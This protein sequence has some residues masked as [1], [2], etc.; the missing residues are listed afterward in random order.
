MARNLEVPWALA[1]LTDG[2]MLIAERPGRLRLISADQ[3]RQGNLDD[4]GRLVA[5][6]QPVEHRGEGGLL[7]MAVSPD[8]ADNRRIYLSHTARD[9]SGALKNVIVSYRLS[10]DGDEL[11][12]R[13]MILDN[14]PGANIHDGLPLRFGDDGK[15]YASTG[16]AAERQLA[17][18]SGS[19]AGKFLRMNPDG[20][21]PDDNPVE[22]SLVWTLGH[23]NAQGFDWH[24]QTGE[25]YATEH[26]PTGGDEVNHVLKG[27]NYGWPLFTHGRN[28]PPYIAPLKTWTPA[29]APSGAAFFRGDSVPQWRNR[30]FIAALR[31][32]RIVSLAFDD[33]DD[34]RRITDSAEILIGSYGRLR[35]VEQGPDGHLY[36]TTSNRDGRGRPHDSDDRVLRLVPLD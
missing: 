10:P 1:W 31:G 26:G 30:L 22:G 18:R 11:T 32:N 8:F 3:L 7:G 25:M 19:L 35:A 15:L 4:P 6:I 29:I 36:V 17:Q 13:Q 16:D 20:S 5:E 34:P 24:P 12:D 14:I 27:Q 9:D 23:R 28:E 33:E 21:V 2:S